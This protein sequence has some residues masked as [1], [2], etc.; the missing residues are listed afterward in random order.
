MTVRYDSLTQRISTNIYISTRRQVFEGMLYVHGNNIVH[1][2]LKPENILLDDQ[3]NVKITDFGF[4]KLLHPGEKLFGKFLRAYTYNV[5]L[6]VLFT[7]VYCD[8]IHLC[9]RSG[10]SSE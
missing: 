6:I 9:L 7:K 5:S 8:I 10:M 2:D 3:L 4:A 1:R